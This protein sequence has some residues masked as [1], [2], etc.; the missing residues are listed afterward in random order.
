MASPRPSSQRDTPPSDAELSLFQMND[1]MNQLDSRFLELR[2]LVLTKDGYVDRRNREDE[3]IRR[4]FESHRAVSDRIDL[5]V[6]SLRSDVTALRSDVNTLRSDVNTL[7]FDM[8]T[9]RSDV[10]RID[11]NVAALR[12]KLDSKDRTNFNYL[13]RTIHAQIRPVPIS[14][15]D[16]SAIFPKWFPRTVWKFWCLRKRSRRKLSNVFEST[17]T[18]QITDVPK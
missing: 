9:L 10:D 18:I 13:A 3:H 8:T 11:S 6:V 1:R 2:S 16:G 15:E 4:E 14:A 5:N 17:L 7:R 12:N